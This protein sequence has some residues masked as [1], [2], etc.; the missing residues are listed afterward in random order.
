MTLDERLKRLEFLE[1]KLNKTEEEFREIDILL[2]EIREEASKRKEELRLFCEDQRVPF[3]NKTIDKIKKIFSGKSKKDP[4]ARP[5]RL[6]EY[7]RRERR[8]IMEFYRSGIPYYELEFRQ[9][10]EILGEWDEEFSSL[11]N[12][13]I[14]YPDN[15][16]AHYELGIAYH[17]HF[18]HKISHLGRARKEFKEAIRLDSTNSYLKPGEETPL[19]YIE[20]R[21]WLRRRAQKFKKRISKTVFAIRDESF[22]FE[23][24]KRAERRPYLYT[25]RY[26]FYSRDRELLKRIAIEEME[27]NKFHMGWIDN[28]NDSS[29]R[30]LILFYKDKSKDEQLRKKYQGRKDVTYGG[31]E[32]ETISGLLEFT[33]S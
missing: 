21:R 17:N 31:L 26:L 3:L 9:E 27:N 19:D 11:K 14:K 22:Y 8:K 2:S 23:I 20:D 1:D 5:N 28:F 33:S 32:K 7:I 4:Y 13:V 30:K 25:G 18:L 6:K 24:F 29:E 16:R 10:E 12:K 15:A